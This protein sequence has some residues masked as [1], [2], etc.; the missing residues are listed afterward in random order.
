MNKSLKLISLVS[1]YIPNKKCSKRELRYR[2]RPWISSRI[3]KVM[4]I[5]DRLLKKWR[6]FDVY[7]GFRNR[8]TN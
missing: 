3:K 1:K 6:A 2:S 7:K 4:K 5:R 8:V